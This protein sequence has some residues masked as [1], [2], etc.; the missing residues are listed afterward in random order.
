[1][2]TEVFFGYQN[3]SSSFQETISLK[4]FRH[5]NFRRWQI[6][7][8]A[9][10]TEVKFACT[11]YRFAENNSNFHR[12]ETITNFSDAPRRERSDTHKELCLEYERI[13]CFLVQFLFSKDVWCR[14]KVF[15]G[16]LFPWWHD[17]AKTL[18]RTAWGTHIQCEWNIWASPA[19]HSDW[20]LLTM[21]QPDPSW[22]AMDTVPM[23]E[24]HQL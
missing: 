19:K 14:L 21:E 2:E 8:D 11:N 17:I 16:W 18:L 5:C 3:Q 4:A 6:C 20:S 1:M 13:Q 10:L 9:S 23:T 7:L 15:L 12:R 22:A 24:K